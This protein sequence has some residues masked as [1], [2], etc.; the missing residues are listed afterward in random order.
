MNLNISL[1]GGLE[2]CKASQN[3][4]CCYADPQQGPGADP[5][6]PEQ[7][8]ERYGREYKQPVPIIIYLL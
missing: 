2:N 3:C 4:P 1:Y 8:L 7:G 5:E 6:A